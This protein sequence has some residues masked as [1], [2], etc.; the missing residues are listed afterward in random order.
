MGRSTERLNQQTSSQMFMSLFTFQSKGLLDLA[1]LISGF[2]TS[3]LRFT[4]S[5]TLVEKVFVTVRVV[6]S[7]SGL[8]ELGTAPLVVPYFYTLSNAINNSVLHIRTRT[9]TVCTVRLLT[10][11]INAPA[12]GQLVREEDTAQRK[13]VT[14]HTHVGSTT[15][16]LHIYI[17]THCVVLNLSRQR[18]GSTVSWKQTL[19]SRHQGS[20]IPQN[21][22]PGFPELWS[23]VPAPQSSVPRD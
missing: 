5:D 19:P 20:S 23:K 17:Y 4:S 22:L 10:T 12:L 3:V 18:D 13:G 9:A 15:L 11:D 16:Y 6:D 7:G 2:C 21:Q 8:V 1:C 14:P